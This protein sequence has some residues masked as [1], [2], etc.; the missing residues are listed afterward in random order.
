MIEKA[1]VLLVHFLLCC[2]ETEGEKEG[3]RERERES[4]AVRNG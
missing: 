2:M 1:V 4:V 3:G